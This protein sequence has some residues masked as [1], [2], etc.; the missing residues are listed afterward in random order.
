VN[1][2]P[3]MIAPTHA[4]FPDALNSLEET[5]LSLVLIEDMTLKILLARGVLSGRDIAEALC[6]PFKLLCPVFADLKNRML[7]AHRTTAAL[8][9][10]YYTLSEQGKQLAQAAKQY[11]A[12]TGPAPVDLADYLKSVALQSIR[13]QHPTEHDL[14]RA[15]NDIVIDD[16]KL[17]ILGPAIHSGRGIFL[18]GQPGN[19]KTTIA[20]RMS[21]CFNSSIFIPYALSVEGEI[22]QLFDPQCHHTVKSDSNIGLDTRW[23]EI[24]RPTV[25]VGGELVMAALELNYNEQ[26]KICEAPLQLKANG[27]VFLID[28]F[29]R[30]RID[31][32]DLLNRWIVPLEKQYD[33]LLLPSGKKIQV[34][35][36]ELIIFSTNLEPKNLVDEAFLRRI[37]YK[38]EVQSPTEIE[39]YSI[40]EYQCQRFDI[41]YSPDI[42]RFLIET[43]YR[44]RREF[45]ICHA[46]DL[47]DQV[48]HICAYRQLD[49]ILTEAL[50][51]EAC[52][53]YF[54]TVV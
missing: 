19:G 41:A 46:R 32:K 14:R 45:R 15:F 49:L 12:Y 43:E 42:V 30:Q 8:G 33:F 25:I 20:E 22:V 9:D 31:S 35:F 21:Q 3:T 51:R 4:F 24:K 2:T 34:P 52:L 11:C 37:P 38:I 23:V 16:A 54:S 40:F 47:L 29:G 13:I 53:N 48:R 6:L 26:L 17:A 7:L 44:D 39:F 5:G 36:D 50:M 27:G 18:F 28:D 1:E 10:F